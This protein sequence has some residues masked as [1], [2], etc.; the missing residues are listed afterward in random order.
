MRSREERSEFIR[1]KYIE[2]KF[3]IRT[4]IDV[5]VLHSDVEQAIQNRDIL[6]LLQAYVEGADFSVPFVDS[7]TILPY[8]S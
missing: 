2:K 4:C 3:A 6:Q 1:A 5:R 7:V 8:P